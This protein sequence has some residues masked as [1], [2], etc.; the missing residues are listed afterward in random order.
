MTAIDAGS[1]VLPAL[2]LV[3]AVTALALLTARRL[4]D[5]TATALGAISASV[6]LGLAVVASI[7]VI[8]SDR[9]QAGGH[10]PVELD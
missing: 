5:T 6:A 1:W 10:P 2:V 7:D 9:P 3:P 4:E 8:G